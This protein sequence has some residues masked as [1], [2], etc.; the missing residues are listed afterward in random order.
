MLS[1]RLRFDTLV[2]PNFSTDQAAV[3]AGVGRVAAAETEADKFG[4]P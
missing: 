2:P 3:G 4:T 1:Q